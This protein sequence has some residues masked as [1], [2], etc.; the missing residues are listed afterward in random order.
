MEV[1]SSVLSLLES[2]VLK[3]IWELN[4][5]AVEAEGL[6]EALESAV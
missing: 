6:V 2:V 1:E 5:F 3:W 4:V